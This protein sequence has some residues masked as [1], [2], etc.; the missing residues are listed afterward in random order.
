[1]KRIAVGVFLLFSLYAVAQAQA[2]S[3]Q[4]MAISDELKDKIT[5][6]M[7]GWAYRSIEPIEGSKNTIIQHWELGNM[8]LRIAIIQYDSESRATEFFND[9]K[10]H[11]RLEEKAAASRGRELHLI[12]GDLPGVGSALVNRL[13]VLFAVRSRLRG[14][15]SL[16]PSQ[17]QKHGRQVA[18]PN[19]NNV[20]KSRNWKRSINHETNFHLRREKQNLAQPA[21]HGRALS[22][23]A[24]L[25]R[26]CDSV[27]VAG[28]RFRSE[29]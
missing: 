28:E 4:L 7:P 19:T 11:L 24:A 17:T 8:A 21:V 29:E 25:V 14:I 3:S 22:L 26:W 13:S 5:R 18:K 15:R 10:Y 6:E 27:R 9:G 1:M 2:V 12:K 16:R 23:A 20:L